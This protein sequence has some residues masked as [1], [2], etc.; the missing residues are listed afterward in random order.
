MAR[1]KPPPEV[2]QNEHIGRRL[3]DEPKLFGASDQASLKGLAMTNF[4]P[5]SDD[6]FSVDRVGEGC[7]HPKVR[8]YLLPRAI[9]AGGRGHEKRTFQGWLTVPARK[10]R[11]PVKDLIWEI[12]SSEEQGPPMDGALPEWSDENLLQNRYH[13]HVPV[14]CQHRPAQFLE[15]L[16]F[17]HVARD[18]FTEGQLHLAPG[19]TL[20]ASPTAATASPEPGRSKMLDAAQRIL[21]RIR[22]LFR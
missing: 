5:T 10:L 20:A 1:W 13:A 7:F 18:L 16:L 11:T 2:G 19:A 14:P 22:A 4:E 21:N 15:R 8:S 12:V 6:E 3:F 9:D 17:A